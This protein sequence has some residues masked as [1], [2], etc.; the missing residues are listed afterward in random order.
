ML[1]LSEWKIFKIEMVG[2]TLLLNCYA[3]IIVNENGQKTKI[4]MEIGS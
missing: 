1:N 4:R 3:Y 2:P